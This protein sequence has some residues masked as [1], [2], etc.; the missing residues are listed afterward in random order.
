V[1]EILDSPA[2]WDRA[3]NQGCQADAVTFGLYCAFAKAS[4][5]INGSFDGSGVAIDEVRSLIDRKYPAR[6]VGYNNDPAV[7][8]AD[9]QKLLQTVEDHLVRQLADGPPPGGRK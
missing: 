6:L 2:K 3:S 7:S 5:E 1:R 9:I 8:L 4:T